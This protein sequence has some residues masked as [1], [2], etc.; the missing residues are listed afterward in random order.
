MESTYWKTAGENFINESLADRVYKLLET[1]IIEM[2]ISPG[3]ILSEDEIAA[4]LNV[5]RSPVREALLRL[6]YAGLVI[7]ERKSRVVATITEAMMIDNYHFWAMTE[8]YAAGHSCKTASPQDLG[9][10]GQ[11]LEQL[12]QSLDDSRQYQELNYRYHSLLV[13]PCP[14]KKLVEL[15]ANALNH[16][17]WGYNFTLHLPDDIGHSNITHHEIFKVYRGKDS[18]ALESMLRAHIENAAQRFRQKYFKQL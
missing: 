11:V 18:A 13:A 6:E 14:Y 16:I 5:S 8:S 4:S 10:I 9:R 12:E 17:R 3:S 15:H 7:K 1:S 2:E